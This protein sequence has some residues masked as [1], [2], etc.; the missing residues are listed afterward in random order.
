MER[1]L[2][3]SLVRLDRAVKVKFDR[4]DCRQ[5]FAR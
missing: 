5:Y 1:S 4:D 3:R 2:S